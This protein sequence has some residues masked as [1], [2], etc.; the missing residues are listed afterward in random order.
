MARGEISWTRRSAEGLKVQ[1]Y[2]HSEGDR[3]RFFIRERRFDRWLSLAAPPLED[4][5]ELLDAVERRIDRRLVRPEEADRLRRTI[6]EQF[7][8]VM[9]P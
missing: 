4:W 8:E 3:W 6:H 9:L 2:A 5:R 7:P 1:V